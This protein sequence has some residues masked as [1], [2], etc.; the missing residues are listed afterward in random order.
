MNGLP[1]HPFLRAEVHREQAGRSFQ[2]QLALAGV[3]L[4]GRDG[5]LQR[6]HAARGGAVLEPETATVTLREPPADVKTKPGTRHV[7][8]P[9]GPVERS[10]QHASLTFGDAEAVI[11]DAH[12]R[13]IAFDRERYLDRVAGAA[14]LDRVAQQVV[15]Y[16]SHTPGVTPHPH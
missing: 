10:E 8:G 2:Q 9:R 6:E 12:Q 13:L 11:G 3:R 15:Q 4:L 14:V 5:K 7:T 16:L 1:T